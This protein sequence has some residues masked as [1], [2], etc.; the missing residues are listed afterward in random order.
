M[1][2]TL[3]RL[4]FPLA[5]LALL[6]ACGGGGRA[7]EQTAAFTAGVSNG[8]VTTDFDGEVVRGSVND[9]RV[10]LVAF[11][12]GVDAT[13]GQFVA[14]AGIEGTPNVGDEVG[15]GTV[16]YDAEYGHVAVFNVSRGETSIQGI[17]LSQAETGTARLTADFSAGTLTGSGTGGG[18]AT[19]NGI[20]V[21]G[22]VNGQSVSGTAT[23]TYST[24]T[25]FATLGNS[26]T[27][28]VR[29]DGAI[30]STGVIAT[31]V[32]KT[33]DVTIAGGLVGT[34]D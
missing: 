13:S 28:D 26:D 15:R 3:T 34:A 1:T 22:R 10:G 23:A 32:G 9:S 27:I 16:T 12:R 31:Y 19:P 4:C 7:D 2:N 5:T 8:Q 6:G 20:R 18:A 11:A 14:T 17:G 30:G 25:S 29:L 33:E 21:D 24:A